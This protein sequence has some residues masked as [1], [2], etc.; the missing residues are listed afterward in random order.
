LGVETA[1]QLHKEFY[2]ITNIE[3]VFSCSDEYSILNLRKM[4]ICGLAKGCDFSRKEELIS[5]VK[6]LNK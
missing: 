3:N 5:I 4:L 2:L 1:T 6:K